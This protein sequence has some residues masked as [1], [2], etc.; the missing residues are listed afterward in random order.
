MEERDE[1]TPSSVATLLH[2]IVRLQ[3]Q[4][5]EQDLARRVAIGQVGPRAGLTTDVRSG[6]HTTEQGR[7]TLLRCLLQWLRGAVVARM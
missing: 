5:E 7:H 6:S 2:R 1:I 4:V 3:Q